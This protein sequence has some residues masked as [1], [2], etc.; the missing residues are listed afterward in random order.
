MALE[1]ILVT[2]WLAPAIVAIVAAAATAFWTLRANIREKAW[3]VV[4]TEKRGEI[5]ALIS[6]MDEFASTIV[7]GCEVD[8][9]NQRPPADRVVAILAMV[10][11]RF[12]P[13]PGPLDPL[14]RAIIETLPLPE[15]LQEDSGQFVKRIDRARTA[16]RNVYELDL[17]E[18]NFRVGR[19][20]T[21]LA[22]TIRNPDVIRDATELL[23][24]AYDLVHATGT[25]FSQIDADKF[26]E[27]WS[28][29]S[30]PIK[31]G[32]RFDLA[33]SS[34]SLGSATRLSW[35]WRLG[36]WRRRRKEK[37]KRLESGAAGPSPPE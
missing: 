26:A 18:L 2:S 6:S 30:S 9:L 34:R 36:R 27:E 3:L 31:L 10:R 12:G 8:G 28:K 16:L 37:A 20:K 1:D 14:P 15:M 5:R 32:L 17:Q 11:Q 7:K 22:L 24:W 23:S 21:T 35:G 19:L 25:S 13:E 33:R 4:Y 29:K